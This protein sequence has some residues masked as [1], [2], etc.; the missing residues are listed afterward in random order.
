MRR[1]LLVPWLC[2]WFLPAT[3]A[4][5]VSP[6][7]AAQI[8]V[9]EQAEWHWLCYGCDPL[10]PAAWIPSP[11]P[12]VTLPVMDDVIIKN[13]VMRASGFE[14]SNDQIRAGVSWTFFGDPTVLKYEQGESENSFWQEYVRQIQAAN[15]DWYRFHRGDKLDYLMVSGLHRKDGTFESHISPGLP[16][17][18]ITRVGRGMSAGALQEI[19]GV[20]PRDS[21]QVPFGPHK[22][23]WVKPLIFEFCRNVSGLR[24]RSPRPV[25]TEPP[26]VVAAAAPPPPVP[27][28][29]ISVEEEPPPMVLEEDHGICGKHGWRCWLAGALVAG[30]ICIFKCGDI[31][32]HKKAIVPED[33]KKGNP[34]PRPQIMFVFHW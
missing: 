5:Q 29:M 13:M 25:M 18:Q 3:A 15:Y 4:A 22:G 31:F 19:R 8:S 2:C 9:N 10:V 32:E 14:K 28:P 20:G 24:D 27:P 12:A 17:I 21:I 26:P 16:M 30:G 6:G 7:I 1:T 23:E 34:P 11:D 33:Q